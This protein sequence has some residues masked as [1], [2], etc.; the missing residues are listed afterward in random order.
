MRSAGVRVTSAKAVAE[1][2]CSVGA[3]VQLSTG[4]KMRGVA[5]RAGRHA[6][7]PAAASPFHVLSMPTAST[8]G[9][10]SLSP[11]QISTPPSAGAKRHLY[12]TLPSSFLGE[13]AQS[14]LSPRTGPAEH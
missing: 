9:R 8:V 14:T 7:P 6:V 1:R 13:T 4:R 10:A 2:A 3:A 11:F 12:L 5:G